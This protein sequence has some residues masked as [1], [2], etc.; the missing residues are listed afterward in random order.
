[1]DSDEDSL[2]YSLL[3]HSDTGAI[4]LDPQTGVFNFIPQTD[5]EGIFRFRYL[6]N[7]GSVDSKPAA[8]WIAVNK[9]EPDSTPPKVLAF[10]DAAVAYQNV[11]PNQI[12]GNVLTN[13]IGPG[14]SVVT[15]VNGK[16]SNVG[17]NLRGEYGTL[18]LT[19]NGVYTYSIDN[20]NPTVNDL[21]KNDVIFE[22]FSY[23]MSNSDVKR[24]STLRI[25]IQQKGDHTTPIAT[26]DNVSILAHAVPMMIQGNVLENDVASN[27]QALEVVSLNQQT[28]RL[29]NITLGKFGA[30]RLSSDGEYIFYPDPEC[31]AVT[32]TPGNLSDAFEYSIN[33]GHS[34]DTGLLTI[35]IIHSKP[36]IANDDLAQMKIAQTNENGRSTVEGNVLDN[37]EYT[38]KPNVEIV[39]KSGTPA[40]DS[41]E[42]EFGVITLGEDGNFVFE[43]D[44]SNPR[45][46]TLAEGETIEDVITYVISDGQTTDQGTLTIN[47]SIA[48]REKLSLN[49]DQYLIVLDD[50]FSTSTRNLLQNDPAMAT[51]SLVVSAVNGR[52]HR[53]GRWTTGNFG[54]VKI[55]RDGTARYEIDRDNPIIAGA[56]G[57]PDMLAERF[58]Y[59]AT[60]GDVSSTTSIR[61]I[62]VTAL[63]SKPASL[64]LARIHTL[65]IPAD[66]GIATG[67]LI[68]GD[69]GL[70][71]ESLEVVSVFSTYQMF[72]GQPRP[73][74]GRMWFSS[75]GSFK[76]RLDRSDPVFNE[77]SAEEY[78][79]HL[80]LYT[81]SNGTIFDNG[82]LTLQIHGN[83]IAPTVLDTNVDFLIDN[84]NDGSITGNLLVEVTTFNGN[85]ASLVKVNAIVV[86]D[87]AV[88]LGKYGTARFSPTGS[89]I[90]EL[91]QANRIAIDPART[92]DLHESFDLT[93]SDGM[94]QS[95]ASLNVNVKPL[96]HHSPN[97]VDDNV[98]L[99]LN[100]QSIV[101]GN[102]LKNDT[103]LNG[104]PLHISSA[105][106]EPIE[107][108]T[109][110]PG[111]YGMLTL[112]SYGMFA[113]ELD[114]SQATINLAEQN[115][116]VD[117]IFTYSTSDGTSVKSAQLTI[118]ILNEVQSLNPGDSNG[119]GVFDSSDLVSVFQAGEYQDDLEGNSSFAEG[120][121]NGDGDFDSFDF[122]FAFAN[123]KFVD[124]TTA[125]DAHSIDHFF[126]HEKRSR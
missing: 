43:T 61:Y 114:E 88:I 52:K 23:E 81:V 25:S 115:G 122:V 108:N 98:N 46:A 39:S 103:D 109:Q 42:T 18:T 73:G 12:S 57:S 51:E 99:L 85:D 76:Y 102:L 7:D 41:I 13:D 125:L 10:Q 35:S 72:S 87:S 83:P 113:Y 78:S 29:E 118:T 3:E 96:S 69:N 97:A 38:N 2:T 26:H 63:D 45:V 86:G 5:F 100:E 67:N 11:T 95:H 54:R 92:H 79:S 21:H 94:L 101:L 124:G 74:A 1:S 71:Q 117:D 106:D 32:T 119:D 60:N 48:P 75:D 112:S 68:V 80:Y 104:H 59:T 65:S 49:E 53:V 30:L 14:I 93:I 17:R 36:L 56:E 33:N 22:S 47:L 20:N 55:E 37:D 111:R 123:G 9:E 16:I 82:Y 44:R 107:T 58:S 84:L 27:D 105:N 121:W 116:P 77:L 62:I 24:T 8:S 66:R 40:A 28:N 120:D 64:Q 126:L 31:I 34:T 4:S 70:D 110:I 15:R 50:S 91:D 19:A 89:F 6:V 90:Y